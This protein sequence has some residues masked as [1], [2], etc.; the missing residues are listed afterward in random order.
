[1]QRSKLDVG[2]KMEIG[3]LSDKDERLRI[4]PA[5]RNHIINVETRAY[6]TIV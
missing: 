2:I 3:S 6:N 5:S 4:G 1:M